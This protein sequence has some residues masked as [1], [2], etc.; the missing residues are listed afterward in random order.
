MKCNLYIHGHPQ[1]FFRGGEKHFQGE[2][3]LIVCWLWAN[4]GAENKNKL[5]IVSMF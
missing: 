1:E 4:E 2:K 5:L 3:F